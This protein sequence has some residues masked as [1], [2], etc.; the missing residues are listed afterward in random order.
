MMEIQSSTKEE[1][2]A[3]SASAHAGLLH[4][5]QG[6]MVSSQRQPTNKQGTTPNLGDLTMVMSRNHDGVM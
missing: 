4:C 3:K 5:R 2:K 1:T 6:N